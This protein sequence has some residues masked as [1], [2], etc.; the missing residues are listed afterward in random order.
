MNE[1]KRNIEIFN[2]ILKIS[3]E[4]ENP[5]LET[6]EYKDVDI[7]KINNIEILNENC[8]NV[9]ERYKKEKPLLL[10]MASAYSIGGGV[11][12]GSSAQEEF[13]C[14]ISNLYTGMQQAKHLYPLE[15]PYVLRD[16]SFFSDENYKNVKTF[17]AD[18]LIASALKFNKKDN[19]HYDKQRNVINNLLNVAHQAK[20]KIIILSAFG[21]GA[22]GNDPHI[23]A[24]IFKDVL[25][26]YDFEKVIFAILDDHNSDDNY[27]TFYNVFII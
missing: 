2:R 9:L 11:K 19:K 7:C 5:I 17:R 26:K 8:F 3:R 4:I 24:S 27:K 15:F 16:V 21:C 20:N 12:S 1:K 23:I 13:L 10:N 25:Q 14:R 6:Y 18:V 22:Y